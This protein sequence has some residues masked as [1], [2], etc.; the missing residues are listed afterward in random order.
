MASIITDSTF[1]AK[2]TEQV[3]NIPAL[4]GNPVVHFT[5]YGFCVFGATAMNDFHEKCHE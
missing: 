3:L 1:P 5:F 2:I 4:A